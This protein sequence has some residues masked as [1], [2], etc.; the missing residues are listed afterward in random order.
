[1]LCVRSANCGLLPTNGLPMP[2]HGVAGL[3]LFTASRLHANAAHTAWLAYKVLFSGATRGGLPVWEP[4]TGPLGLVY[5]ALTAERCRCDPA[6]LEKPSV[7]RGVAPHPV[8]VVPLA[9]T[10][11]TLRSIAHRQGAAGLQAGVTPGSL[12][13]QGS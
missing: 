8:W 2:K 3:F 5:A 4:H 6:V 12:L 13:L 7:V 9:S 10:V 11:P 1:V